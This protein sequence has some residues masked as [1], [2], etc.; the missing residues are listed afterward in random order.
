ME[1]DL[2]RLGGN[3]L[4]EALGKAKFT[5]V[6]PD[7]P[8]ED[9]AAKMHAVMEFSRPILWLLIVALGIES[10][11]ALRFGRRRAKVGPA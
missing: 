5:W 6:S 1:G 9:L 10:F 8:V 7:V 2:T 4:R 11:L 3:E